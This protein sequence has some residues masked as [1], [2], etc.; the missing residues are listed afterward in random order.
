MGTP[1]CHWNPMSDMQI[2]TIPTVEELNKI[3]KDNA[4]LEMPKPFT[5]P[6]V[7]KT[8]VA[9][10]SVVGVIAVVSIMIVSS[11]LSFR[12]DAVKMEE[13]IIA[14][15]SQNQNS[16]DSMWKKFKEMA[17]V[18][19]MYSN[20]LKKV[21][22]SAIQGRYGEDGSRAMFQWIQEHNPNLDSTTYI[23]LQNAIESG[24]TNFENEQKSLIDR[25]M[26]YQMLLR[27]N[28]ALFVNW[29]LKFPKIDL[30][31]YS[32]VTSAPTDD[33]FTSKKADEIKLR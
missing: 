27:S 23:K 25:K 9:V 29:V 7:N 33:A 5:M 4:N 16:Y 10:L 19:D 32:I 17:Q 21:Y 11:L 20:D 14:Q 1:A 30:D 2:K 24:R 18:T 22:D 8:L 28:R 12:A 13:T 6:N 31:K 3:Y 26:A 15:Y